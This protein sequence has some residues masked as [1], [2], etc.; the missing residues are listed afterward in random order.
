MRP[1]TVPVNLEAAYILR[2]LL[3]AWNHGVR[4]TFIYE[5][6]DEFPGS[7]YGLLRHDFTE[8][9]AYVALRNL[10]S[11]LNDSSKPVKPGWL[12][13]SIEHSNPSLCHTLLQKTD[14]SYDLI[15]WLERSSYDESIPQTKG[16]LPSD[17]VQIAIDPAFGVSQLIS[18]NENGSTSHKDFATPSSTLALGVNDRLTILRIV[19]R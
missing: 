12:A 10:L 11:I 2:T 9:P 5:L 4:R 17:N 6:L 18:F 15:L 8:K 1:G 3:L 19:A 7:G 14:G 16:R 13:F